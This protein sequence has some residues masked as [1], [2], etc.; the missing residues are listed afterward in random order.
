MSSVSAQTG[1]GVVREGLVMKSVILGRDQ[2]YTLYLPPDY[3]TSNRRYPVVYLLHGYTDDDTGWL[4][5]GEVNGIADAAIAQMEIP[6][7]IIVMPDGGVS[8]YINDYQNKVRWE[9]MMFNEL[10]PHIDATYRTR[11]SSRYRGIA[12]LSMGGY[13]AT[14][15]SMRRPDLFSACAAFSAAYL[16]EE[17][18]LTM[19]AENYDPTFGIL[20][21]EKLTGEARLTAH[22]KTYSV[23]HQAAVMPEAQLKRVRWYFDCGDGDFVSPSNAQLHI[24]LHQRGIPHEY[25]ARDGEH[26]WTYWRTGLKDGLA[27]IGQSFHQ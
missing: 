6:P 19:P 1:H 8:W 2:R 11:A 10:I 24:T 9:D 3:E 5:F 25:R 20:Y 22:W 13:G 15:L 4:Q 23:L 16:M 12:G 26:T 17:D 27:F 21:G 7:M 18:V 14:I